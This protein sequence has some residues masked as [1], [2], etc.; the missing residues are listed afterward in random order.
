MTRVIL[1]AVLTATFVFLLAPI[2]VVVLASFNGVGVLSFPPRAFTTRWYY[3]IDPSFYLALWVSLVVGVITVVLAVLVGV[4]GALGLARGRFRGRDAINTGRI[5]D[6]QFDGFHAGVG[7][8]HGIEVTTPPAG[9][10]DLVAQL[11][12]R[13]GKSATDTRT[14]AG[15][16]HSVASEF[17]GSFPS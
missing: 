2:V 5:G 3:E 14:A 15:N 9:N 4:P 1:P 6:V 10:D 8:D 11:M 7:C 12:Q 17:H 13:F 16:K